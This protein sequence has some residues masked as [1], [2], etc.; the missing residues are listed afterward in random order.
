M[1]NSVRNL[2][3]IAVALLFTAAAIWVMGA[4]VVKYRDSH[5]I[6]LLEALTLGQLIALTLGL[7]SVVLLWLQSR[8]ESKWRRLLSYHQYFSSVPSADVRAGMLGVMTA[9]NLK[10]RLEGAG[11]PLSP[12]DVECIFKQSQDDQQKILLYLDGFEQFS[13]SVNAG[14]V[15]AGYAYD[16]E[17][18]RLSRIY[19]VFGPLIKRVRQHSGKAYQQLENLAEHWEEQRNSEARDA[20]NGQRKPRV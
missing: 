11:T 13:G 5:G 15:D 17:G 8:T 10:D 9:C 3:G 14:I 12:A 20:R 7:G 19:K 2:L 6:S 1:R 16:Q 4:V 18:G